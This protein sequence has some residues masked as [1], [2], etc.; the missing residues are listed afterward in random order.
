LERLTAE[1][2]GVV[3]PCVDLAQ[4]FDAHRCLSVP[5]ALGHV[6]QLVKILR[7]MHLRGGPCHK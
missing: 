2:E 6:N 7:H 4:V 5:I 1:Q 3:I